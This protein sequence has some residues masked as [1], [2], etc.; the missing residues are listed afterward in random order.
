MYAITFGAHPSLKYLVS[1]MMTCQTIA[2]Y[3]TPQPPTIQMHII[4]GG[5]GNISSRNEY[6]TDYHL[7]GKIEI[8]FECA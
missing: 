3:E 2:H 5:L 8:R 6:Q 4:R 1:A 7:N